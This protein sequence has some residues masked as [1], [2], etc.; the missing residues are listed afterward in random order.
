MGTIGNTNVN[1]LSAGTPYRLLVGGD[2]SINL[3]NNDAVAVPTRV[4]ATGSMHTGFF[5]HTMVT[6]ADFF[7]FIGNPYQSVVDF[8]EVVANHITGYLYLWDAS[9]AGE[10][11]N[12]G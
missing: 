4:R 1:S 6:G 5:S 3:T 7:N 10:F 11:G 9:I 8:S 12:G 2:R